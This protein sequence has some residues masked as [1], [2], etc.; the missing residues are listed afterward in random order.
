[1]RSICDPGIVFVHIGGNCGLEQEMKRLQFGRT[2]KGKV[3]VRIKKMW[4]KLV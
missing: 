3:Y 1:M 2:G 4:Q